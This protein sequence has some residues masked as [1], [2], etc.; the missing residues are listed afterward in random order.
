MTV[1]K[2]KLP[3]GLFYCSVDMSNLKISCRQAITTRKEQLYIFQ[4]RL[5]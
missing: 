2:L 1:P 3:I 5:Q 4:L